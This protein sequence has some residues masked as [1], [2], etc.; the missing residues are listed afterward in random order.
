[1]KC[2]L[3]SATILFAAVA[4]TANA[5]ERDFPKHPLTIVV[6]QAPG[7]PTDVIVRSVQQKMAES[8]GQS[9]VV[10]NRTG[11]GGVIG[12]RSVIAAAPDGYTIGIASPTSHGLVSALYATP[13]YDPLKEFRPVGGIAL[14]PGVLVS[15]KT[16]TSDC[17]FSTLLEKIKLTEIRYGSAGIGTRSHGMGAVFAQELHSKMLHVPY[18]GLSLAMTDMYG[19]QIDIVFDSIGSAASH[20]RSGKVCA[21]AVQAPERLAAFPDVPTFAELGYPQ[22]NRPDWFAMMVR[23]A[24]PNA[25]VEKLNSALN[26]ALTGAETSKTLTSLGAIPTPGSPEDLSKRMND[27]ILFWRDMVKKAGI[28][29]I[30]M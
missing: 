27:E 2:L 1:M 22:L 11:A 25:V 18:R 6:Q 15:S 23:K 19:G 3:R 7:G 12:V 24:T 29:K 28:E 30:D 4:A 21:L 17:K 10:E 9:I 20:V 8:L 16:L 5:D 13:P 26:Q 14:V